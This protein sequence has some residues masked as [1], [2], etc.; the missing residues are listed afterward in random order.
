MRI[1]GNLF[2]QEWNFV[3]SNSPKT[4]QN[5]RRIIDIMTFFI[6]N[7]LDKNIDL[8]EL[9]HVADV[10][11]STVTRLFKKHFSLTPIQFINQLRIKKAQKILATTNQKMSAIAHQIGIPDPFYFSKIFKKY[12]GS[13]PF[14][15]RKR[16]S[17]L[18]RENLNIERLER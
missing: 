7:N 6:E 11:P 18:G 1:L 10:S 5:G 12:T 4:K 9:T 2:I 8:N 13:T 3:V 17:I 15:Y 14:A 16:Y